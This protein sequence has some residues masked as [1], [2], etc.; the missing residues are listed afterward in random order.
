VAADPNPRPKQRRMRAEDRRAQLVE[1]AQQVFVREGSMAP[2]K[3]IADEAGVHEALIFQHF[4]SK[5][6]LF[7]A[8][9]MEP[10]TELVGELHTVVSK[11]H[12]DHRNEARHE[13]LDQIHTDML[14]IL[15]RLVPMLG[16]A[17]Y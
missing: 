1:V 15:T 17:L 9:I 2:T 13:L 12:E 5:E 6:N 14:R 4:G 8:A 3:L 11:L 7:E 16:I 10:L